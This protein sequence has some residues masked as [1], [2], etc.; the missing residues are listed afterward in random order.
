MVKNNYSDQV[1]DDEIGRNVA[2]IV[3]KLNACRILVGRPEG[4]R[5]L[6]RLRCTW[7]DNIK[8][9]LREIGWGFVE[10]IV[11]AHDRDH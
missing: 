11:L 5:P 3:K 6:G 2:R 7:K 9:D 4:K 1:K 10:W 8:V